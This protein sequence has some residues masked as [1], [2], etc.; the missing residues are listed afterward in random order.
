MRLF[1]PWAAWALA[2]CLLF[3]PAANASAAPVE[4]R[5]AFAAGLLPLSGQ[6]DGQPAGLF[7]EVLREIESRGGIRLNWRSATFDE[8]PRGG[9]LAAYDL[10][11]PALTAPIA[12]PPTLPADRIATRPVTELVYARW[13]QAARAT[14]TA[15]RD[16]CG[17]RYAVVDRSEAQRWLRNRC[18]GTRNDLRVR[19]PDEALR[20]LAEGLVD[21]VVGLREPMLLAAREAGLAGEIGEVDTVARVPAG[22]WVYRDRPDLVQALNAGIAALQAS[23]E[24]QAMVERATGAA[25]TPPPVAES[26][27]P[28]STTE[29]DATPAAPPTP[30]AVAA[31]A[32]RSNE[33]SL[34]AASIVVAFA[35]AVLACAWLAWRGSA[36]RRPVTPNLVGPV[37]AVGV[38]AVLA[39]VADSAD[40]ANAADAPNPTS[41]SPVAPAPMPLLSGLRVLL[42]EGRSGQRLRLQRA[43]QRWQ[44]DVTVV[45]GIEALWAVFDAAQRHARGFDVVLLDP[46]QD[47]DTQALATRLR[48]AAG[49]R[50]LNVLTL[51]DPPGEPV[52]S[53]ALLR[54]IVSLRVSHVSA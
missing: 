50:L 36:A 16:A 32:A 34:G 8:V 2:F 21:A 17:M 29:A 48:G 10:L 4:A 18:K 46:Q 19:G 12:G 20:A 53:D 14:E 47:G 35:V 33:A 51:D 6:R 40:P 30:A 15:A 54:L 24:L 39:P 27:L 11:L 52:R 49:G 26:R 5:A 3:D 25:L 45:S 22:F 38:D 7:V 31:P 44:A 41:A 43:L 1:Q 9:S 23:G 37:S 13:A 42:H 28:T